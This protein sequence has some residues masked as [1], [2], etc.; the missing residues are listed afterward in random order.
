[1][2]RIIFTFSTICRVRND[3][4]I[5]RCAVVAQGILTQLSKWCANPINLRKHEVLEFIL[6]KYSEKLNFW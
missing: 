5:S 3:G 4:V 2:A 1:M 6:S